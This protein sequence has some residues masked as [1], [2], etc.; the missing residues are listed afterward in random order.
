MI[1]EVSFMDVKAE[2]SIQSLYEQIKSGHTY[3][4]EYWG[5][6]PV[7]QELRRR[8]GSILFI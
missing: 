4:C 3:I 8:R 2:S 1:F 5:L 7:N 6:V